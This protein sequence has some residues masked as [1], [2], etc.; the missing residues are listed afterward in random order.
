MTNLKLA[1]GDE[2]C[3]AIE[4]V[5]EIEWRRFQARTVE[6]VLKTGEIHREDHSKYPPFTSVRFKNENPEL[7]AKLES[8]VANYR[9]VVAWKM[10]GYERLTLPGTNWVIQPAFVD[11]VIS[12]ARSQEPRRYI[13]EQYPEFASVAYAD[14]LGLAEHVCKAL[15]S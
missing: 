14:M 9:G 12:E 5:A 4:L 2:L 10:V 15:T 7:V 13:A 3:C 6:V 11:Q 8:A 1:N